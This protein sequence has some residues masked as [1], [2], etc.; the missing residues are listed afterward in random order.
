VWS[1]DG[2]WLAG[3]E[4][5]VTLRDGKTGELLQELPGYGGTAL[6]VVW[7]ADGQL[8][9]T[10][11][12]SDDSHVRIWD[13]EKGQQI[14]TYRPTN[15]VQNVESVAF[16]GRDALVYIDDSDQPYLWSW[17]TDPE[18]HTIR[19]GTRMPDVNNY[20]TQ[21]DRTGRYLARI[22]AKD[23]RLLYITDLE[24]GNQST[25]YA[26][27][28]HEEVVSRIVFSPDSQQVATGDFEGIIYVWDVSSAGRLRQK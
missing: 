9:A 2:R 15:H 12:D 5:Q 28:A 19:H 14:A 20:P 8:L 6:S 25:F 18:P 11:G 13:I 1:P 4:S 7:S 16:Y 24:T 10:G 26:E 3:A 27:D 22:D 17:R 23:Y 21:L